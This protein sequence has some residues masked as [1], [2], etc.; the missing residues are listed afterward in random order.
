MLCV[1]IISLS[2]VD[3]ERVGSSHV[4]IILLSCFVW[5][6]QMVSNLCF[7]CFPDSVQA[8]HI[9]TTTNKRARN[10]FI[11]PTR[12]PPYLLHGSFSFCFFVCVLSFVLFCF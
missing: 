9:T 7:V 5:V 1:I 6:Q 11:M 3:L 8:A 2:L 12:T 4:C 10:T